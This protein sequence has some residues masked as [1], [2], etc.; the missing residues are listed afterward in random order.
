MD[1]PE[2]DTLPNCEPGMFWNKRGA[3]DLL[4]SRCMILQPQFETA[5]RTGP[6]SEDGHG[7]LFHSFAA[8]MVMN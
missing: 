3:E 4:A 8:F 1:C 6:P 7:A 2:C 5:G